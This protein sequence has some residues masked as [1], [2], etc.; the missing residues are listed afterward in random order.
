MPRGDVRHRRRR[1]VDDEV[2]VRAQRARRAGSC[3]RPVGV[4]E[5]CVANRRSRRERRRVDIVEIRARV[6]GLDRVVE[7]QGRRAGTTR[8]VRGPV[9]RTGLQR[10]LRRPE[11]VHDFAEGHGDRDHDACLVGAVRVPRGDVRHRRRRRVDDEV[12]VRA[13]RARRARS[14][15]RPVGIVGRLIPNR[16]AVQS[17]RARPHVVEIR[18]R[19]TGLD[20]VAE[21]ECVAAAAACVVDSP[22]SRTGLQ[23]QLW[24][25][26]DIDDLAEGHRDRDHDACLV[27]AVRVTRGDIRHRRRR[28]VDDEVLVRAERARSAGSRER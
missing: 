3:K 27:G 8:V 6:A 11:D 25:P 19:V 16:P 7:G 22:V 26:G 23:G 1:R 2:L 9:S 28:R 13:Q 5:C 18:A 24:R 12:L 15:K 20:G 10:E 21:G 14:C 4:V 17:E